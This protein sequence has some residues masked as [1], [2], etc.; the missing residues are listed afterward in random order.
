MQT[1]QHLVLMGVAGTG[2]TTLAALLGDRLGWPTAEGD[3]F[4][5]AANIAKMSAGTP[6]TDDDRWPWLEAIA[7]WMRDEDEA[8][9]STIVT[10]SALKRAYREVLAATPGHVRFVHLTGRAGLV[11]DRM[12]HRTDHFMPTTLLPSQLATL[13]PLGPDEDGITVEVDATPEA[14]AAR[15]LRALRLAAR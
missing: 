15:V 14:L 4:H 10:C 7:A 2:K 12:S 3:D 1:R 8:G 13:E 5:P 6:L 11:A 9:A